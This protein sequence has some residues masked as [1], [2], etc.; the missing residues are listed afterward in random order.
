MDSEEG[1]VNLL[2]LKH[3]PVASVKSGRSC[4]GGT[5]KSVHSM[6]ISP[7]SDILIE[8]EVGEDEVK[9]KEMRRTRRPLKQ[10]NE[11]KRYENIPNLHHI[12]IKL[13]KKI[14]E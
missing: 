2:Q 12:D 3:C 14:M 10:E 8:N 4:S 9:G 7:W 6:F 5:C 1:V 11:V 13:R